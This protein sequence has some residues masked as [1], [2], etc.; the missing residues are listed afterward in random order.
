VTRARRL[1]AALCARAAAAL[2]DPTPPTLP[3]APWTR[4]DAT[5]LGGSGVTAP[6]RLADGRIAVFTRGPAT[7][8]LVDPRDGSVRSSPVEEPPAECTSQLCIAP[9]CDAAGRLVVLGVGG[10]LFRLGLDGR[11]RVA[12]QLPGSLLGVVERIDGTE[13]AAVS[14]QTNVDSPH[15]AFVALRTDGSIAATRIFGASPIPPPVALAGGGVA[16][17]VPRGLAVF[18]RAG[19]IRVVP[20]VEGILHLINAGDAAFAVT[21]SSLFPLDSQGVAGAPRRLLAPARGWTSASDGPAVARIDGSPSGFLLVDRAGNQRRVDAAAN[22]ET[23]L[24]DG[25]GAMLVATRLGRLAALNA[26]GSQRWVVDLGSRPIISRVALGPDG[27]AWVTAADGDLL[28]L[29]SPPPSAQ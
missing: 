15:V 7:L 24:V 23:A 22:Y 8:A 25:A 12:A 1:A 17:G 27:D 20:S 18:D 3:A 29:W 10:T 14:G 13:V 26:D 5:A 4:V 21:Q 9:R 19:T 16:V 6:V 2:A 11:V 28:H